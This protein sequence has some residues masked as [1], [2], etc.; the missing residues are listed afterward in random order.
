MIKLVDRNL[1]VRARAT[2]S[3]ARRALHIR[4]NVGVDQLLRG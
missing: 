2:T 4:R 3:V 1:F